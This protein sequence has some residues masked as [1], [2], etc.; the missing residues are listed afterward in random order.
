M[1]IRV[2]YRNLIARSIPFA[3]DPLSPEAVLGSLGRTSRLPP[4]CYSMTVVVAVGS[5][6][7]LR[8]VR[9]TWGKVKTK[10]ELTAGPK[11]PCKHL[12]VPWV[13]VTS[14]LC[15]HGYPCPRTSKMGAALSCFLWMFLGRNLSRTYVCVCLGIATETAFTWMSDVPSL[16]SSSLLVLPRFFFSLKKPVSCVL[17]IKSRTKNMKV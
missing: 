12:G 2:T 7:V 10:A 11:L 6:T 17:W 15:L 3:R 5:K 1:I 4:R 9:R 16:L 13:S 8:S 14:A